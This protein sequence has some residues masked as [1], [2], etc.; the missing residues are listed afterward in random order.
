MSDVT[1]ADD[2]TYTGNVTFPGTDFTYT[3][4][5]T[6]TSFFWSLF[7]QKIELFF[8]KFSNN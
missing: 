8:F 5:V 7:L 3:G 6:Y 2:F 4:D 1:Y